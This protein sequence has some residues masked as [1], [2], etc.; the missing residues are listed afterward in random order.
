[1]P[2]DP[3]VKPLALVTGAAIRLGREIALALADEGYAI[4]LH[5]HQSAEPA[6]ELSRHLQDKGVPVV[7]LQADLTVPEQIENIFDQVSVSG[8]P[9]KVLI[10]SA[11]VMHTGNLEDTS[12]EN[13]DATFALNLRAPWL[14]ARHAAHLMKDHGVIINLTDAASGRPWKEYAAYSVSKVGL[15]A[16]TRLLARSL[17]PGIRVNAVAP[18]LVLPAPGFPADKWQRLV[19]RLPAK[20]SGTA[21]DIVRAVLFLI[22]NEYITG[23]TLAVDG[24]YRLM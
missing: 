9:L 3:Q 17:A 8:Y 21:E 16:L 11:A 2:S 15:E 19:E 7:L 12:V 6:Q 20:K 10:N 1:M 23:Q 18:G 4:G 5:Y 13:W 22:Q 24:G 14:C